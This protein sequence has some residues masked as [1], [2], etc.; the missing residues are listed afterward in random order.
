MGIAKIITKIIKAVKAIRRTLPGGA[1]FIA[2]IMDTEVTVRANA[3][4]RHFGKFPEMIKGTLLTI[5]A[6]IIQTLLKILPGTQG[7]QTQVTTII[8]QEARVPQM[9]MVGISKTLVLD[10]KKIREGEVTHEV[11]VTRGPGVVVEDITTGT[12]TT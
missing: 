12:S 1:S 2:S 10:H 4:E 3:K 8:V 11:R 7:L 6:T 9:E 5:T